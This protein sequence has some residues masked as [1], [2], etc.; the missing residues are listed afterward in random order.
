MITL[1]FK[2]LCSQ[3]KARIKK[4]KEEIEELQAMRCHVIDQVDSLVEE[5]G[6]FTQQHV[7]LE[8]RRAEAIALENAAL[9]KRLGVE[10]SMLEGELSHRA[11]EVKNHQRQSYFLQQEMTRRKGLIKV[12]LSELA[13]MD[14]KAGAKK[15]LMK[16]QKKDGIY[17]ALIKLNSV[18][19]EQDEEDKK[20]VK[21]Q[22]EEKEEEV[23]VCNENELVGDEFDVVEEEPEPQV[24]A[25]LSVFS[26]M[27]M[28]EASHSGVVLGTEQSTG[29]VSMQSEN[30][31]DIK[32]NEV[33]GP[34]EERLPSLP[35]A[36]ADRVI[37][38][39]NAIASSVSNFAVSSSLEML[40]FVMGAAEEVRPAKIATRGFVQDCVDIAV[41]NLA[42]SRVVSE[43]VVLSNLLVG[44]E[45][46]TKW[47]VKQDYLDMRNNLITDF[48]DSS[49]VTAFNVAV[50]IISHEAVAK[51][52]RA[53][54]RIKV[55]SNELATK[56]VSG[57]F[58]SVMTAVVV[59]H[60]LER[61]ELLRIYQEKQQRIID[62]VES[63]CDEFSFGA[64]GAALYTVENKVMRYKRAMD[65]EKERSKDPNS[66][67]VMIHPAGAGFALAKMIKQKNRPVE[68]EM[69]DIDA[70]T[71]VKHTFPSVMRSNGDPTIE[72]LLNEAL[73][74]TG[75][76][77]GR[78]MFG[79]E[80]GVIHQTEVEHEDW[81]FDARLLQD[82]DQV[83]LVAL[84]S[85]PGF[86]RSI[87]FVLTKEQENDLENTR[88]PSNFIKFILISALRD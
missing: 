78:V 41:T 50:N 51:K 21:E 68:L 8:R 67:G 38:D 84:C 20:E 27:E 60:E 29:D 35:V 26:S 87:T 24:E 17:A 71:G 85:V 37:D 45:R 39:V 5:H 54:Q 33:V 42:C 66:V 75:D 1:I 52:D 46:A 83:K 74:N 59:K 32:V 44:F 49:M 2:F 34:P 65:F 13:D 77:Y 3:K 47:R 61:L 36:N 73:E 88:N 86:E 23:Q 7:S 58:N 31:E 82:V 80:I 12:L 11:S 72:D 62:E 18:V 16:I 10:I 48:V 43:E 6:V 63:V 56:M 22:S 15:K 79:K 76:D 25:S 55:F 30:I 14:K 4:L 9:S 40:W 69:Y 19:D 53:A 28:M 81:V 57:V 64:I 70:K